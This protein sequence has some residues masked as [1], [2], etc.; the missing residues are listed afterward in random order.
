M[1]FAKKE[2]TQTNWRTQAETQ[3]EFGICGIEGLKL[4]RDPDEKGGRDHEET[5]DEDVEECVAGSP[6]ATGC[7]SGILE[8][9]QVPYEE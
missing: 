4:C 5:G 7:L 8:F 9:L 3:Q 6:H 1:I 2:H